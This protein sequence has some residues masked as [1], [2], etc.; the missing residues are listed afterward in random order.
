[1]AQ[2]FGIFNAGPSVHTSGTS[3]IAASYVKAIE[4]SGARVVPV[5]MNRSYDYYEYVH[6]F[7]LLE[8][9]FEASK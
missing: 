4:S 5:F 6:T 3:Y 2:N 1:M 7:S 8:F 9:K